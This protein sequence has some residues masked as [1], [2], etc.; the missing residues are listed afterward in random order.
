MGWGQICREFPVV[1]SLSSL[2]RF[3][4]GQC[5]LN[6]KE[7]SGPFYQETPPGGGRSRA[8]LSTETVA[9]LRQLPHQRPSM[10]LKCSGTKHT[11]KTLRPGVL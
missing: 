5:A 6:L 10:H 9:N 11:A 3:V 1:K 4:T 8:A 2:D 7:S